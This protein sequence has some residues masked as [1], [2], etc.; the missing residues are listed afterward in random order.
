MHL[1]LLSGGQCRWWCN[2]CNN[3]WLV[4]WR[5]V[6]TEH[7]AVCSCSNFWLS[8]AH[9]TPLVS[10][11]YSKSTWF[12]MNWLRRWDIW[13]GNA[14]SRILPV[15]CSS[16]CGQTPLIPAD[17]SLQHGGNAMVP[18]PTSVIDNNMVMQCMLTIP[19]IILIQLLFLNLE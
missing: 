16:P 2:H 9:C 10:H 18:S 1:C 15:I 13:L 5:W 12:E 14:C 19:F 3:Q 8:N 17:A 7:W 11:S 4:W 6:S